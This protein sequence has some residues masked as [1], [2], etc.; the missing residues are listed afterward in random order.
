MSAISISHNIFF[1]FPRYYFSRDFTG[2]PLLSLLLFDDLAEHMLLKLA[3]YMGED[4]WDK[5]FWSDNDVDW[6]KQSIITLM[7]TAG[8]PMGTHKSDFF[9][10]DVLLQ[11]FVVGTK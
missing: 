2:T 3:A 4:I 9:S 6:T 8:E 1:I 10:I 11:K 5:R 7:D